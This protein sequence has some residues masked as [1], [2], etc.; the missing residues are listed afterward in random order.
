MIMLDNVVRSHGPFAF[1]NVR[2]NRVA[3]V[4]YFEQVLPSL[5][6]EAVIVFDGIHCRAMLDSLST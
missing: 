1:I 3:T 4:S 2:F 5:T 6:K